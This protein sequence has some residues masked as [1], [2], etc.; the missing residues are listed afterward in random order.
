[1]FCSY[2][3][4]WCNEGVIAWI[5]RSTAGHQIGIDGWV[6]L[7]RKGKYSGLLCQCDK[8]CLWLYVLRWEEAK[9]WFRSRFLGS[10]NRVSR[11]LELGYSNRVFSRSPVSHFLGY[12]EGVFP[13]RLL[14]LH[15]F[16]QS[17]E[18]WQLVWPRQVKVS[19]D[20]LQGVIRLCS[21]LGL[22]T[23]RSLKEPSQFSHSQNPLAVSCTLNT[24]LGPKPLHSG[25]F[26]WLPTVWKTTLW[27]VNGH[28]GDS[29]V[30][31][32]WSNEGR[33]STRPYS[34]GVSWVFGGCS[35]LL[36]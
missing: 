6:Q 9:N 23:V 18:K 21:L 32:L 16:W 1:M 26:A 3:T 4:H 24:V 17:P 34:H 12:I 10:R 31:Q 19:P 27:K 25:C 7:K 30:M 22:L 33:E 14:F 5:L 29:G 13:Q 28:K 36:S 11:F 2:Q 15:L 8:T 20:H 35:L